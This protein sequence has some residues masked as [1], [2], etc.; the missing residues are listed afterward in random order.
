MCRSFLRAVGLKQHLIFDGTGKSLL[1]T[2]GR[3]ISR[4]K[5]Q[6][7]RVHLCIVLAS[8]DSCM[9]NIKARF[10]NGSL[11]HTVPRRLQFFRSTQQC[12]N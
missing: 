5:R 6:G 7:Y 8:Y 2:C 3:I 4:M 12:P 9:A 10:S 1:N 11:T